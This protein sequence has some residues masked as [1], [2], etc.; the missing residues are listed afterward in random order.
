MLSD[1]FKDHNDLEGQSVHNI[2][3]VYIESGK[4]GFQ[5][6]SPFPTADMGWVEELRNVPSY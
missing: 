5:V 3:D 4:S 1:D 6:F 2:G